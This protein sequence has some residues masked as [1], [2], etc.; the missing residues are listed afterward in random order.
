MS[1]NQF[2][3]NYAIPPGETLREVLEDKN[4]DPANLSKTIGISVS[5][6][7][8]ILNGEEPITGEIAQTFEMHLDIPASFWNNLEANYKN[9]LKQHESK[10]WI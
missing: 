4:L 5:V 6:I 9:L 7:E 1:E 2:K 10:R 8:G 3:P